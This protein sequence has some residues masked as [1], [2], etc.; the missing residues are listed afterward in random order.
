MGEI[1]LTIDDRQI[2]AQDGQTILAIARANGIYIPA[3]C[4][5]TRCSPTLACRLCMV[6]ADGKRA[7]SCNAKAKDAM[8][9][10]TN[11]EEIAAERRAIMQ[12]YCV[13]HPLQCGVCDRSGECELQDNTLFQQVAAQVLAVPDCDRKA[14]T[15]N[16]TSYDPA[17]C[18]VCERCITVCKDVIGVSA[19]ATKARGGEAIN[20]S[21]KESMSKDSYTIWNK[22]NK[23]LIDHSARGDLCT[24]CGECA[25]VC[26][27]G[28]MTITGFQYSSNAWELER[29]PSSCVHCSSACHL[30]YEVKQTGIDN[31]QKKIYRVSNDFHFQ[32]LCGAGRLGFDFANRGAKKSSEAFAA[33]IAALGHA[34]AIRFTSLITNEEILL[35]NKLKKQLKIKLINTEA[36]ELSQFLKAFSGVT[37]KTLY[38]GSKEAIGDFTVSIGIRLSNDNPALRYAIANALSVKK[39]AAIDFHPIGDAIIDTMNKNLLPLRYEAGAEESVLG[40]LLAR[41][42]E[43]LPSAVREKFAGFSAEQLE[44][45]DKLAAGK[46]GFTLIAGRDLFSHPRAANIARLLGLLE[47]YSPFSV[48]ISPE[49]VNSLGVALLADLDES[50]EGYTVGYGTAGDF[51]LTPFG[52]NGEDS[53]D[54]PSLNQQEG[55][56]INL[57]KRV[58]PIRPALGY[59]GY[60]LVELANEILGEEY[61]RTVELTL[62]LP[63]ANGGFDELENHFGKDGSENRGFVL[64][65]QPTA[66]SDE[67]DL[68][69][70]IKLGGAIIYLCHPIDGFNRLIAMSD[71]TLYASEE[72]MTKHTLFEAQSVQLDLGGVVLTREVKRDR[73]LTGEFAFLSVYDGEVSGY[74]F[75]SATLTK[76]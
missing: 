61:E 11:S 47:K 68:P 71:N 5:L 29:I 58:V 43:S 56:V 25:A 40:A 66:S 8:V 34:R 12:A 1:R 60:T 59:D 54:M 10:R 9:V 6:D 63:F 53:L 41:F 3:L 17:L 4:F 33:A 26:P 51:E 32:S 7:Y 62:D 24:D 30:V 76:G 64:T 27:T 69:A 50:A 38:S 20:D 37:G 35:L 48:L 74:R 72:F 49:C 70:P 44:A 55:T 28:A 14:V 36:Y 23:S 67:F 2:T 46:T 15:W 45:I 16:K 65:P 39:G 22:M 57:D 75:K 31:H 13:N 52:A 21:Y 18:I 42:A 73:Y 19:L